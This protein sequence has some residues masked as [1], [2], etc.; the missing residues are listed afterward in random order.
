MTNRPQAAG[1]VVEFLR[2]ALAGGAL[3][4]PKLEVTARAAGLLGEHQDI[5][6]SKVFKKA[7][8]SLGIRSTYLVVFTIVF[9]AAICFSIVS[10]IMGHT[11]RHSGTG[12]L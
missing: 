11:K 12:R 10:F 8:K 3:G 1:L 6:H 9:G 4:V 2:D 5:T 7:K